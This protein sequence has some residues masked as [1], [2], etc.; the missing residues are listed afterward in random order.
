MITIE[1]ITLLKKEVV[2]EENNVNYT[3]P[4]NQMEH[5]RKMIKLNHVKEP[6]HVFFSFRS[7]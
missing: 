3:M 2:I 4:I 6:Q 1:K 7:K 5:L